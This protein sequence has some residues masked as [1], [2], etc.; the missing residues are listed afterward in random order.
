MEYQLRFGSLK[1]MLKKILITMLIVIVGWT[2]LQPP[3]ANAA[4]QLAAI[5]VGAIMFWGGAALV[6]STGIALGLDPVAMG[7][8][9]QFGE[10]VWNGSNELM[11]DSWQS[12][13]SA[14]QW[15][16]T[17]SRYAVTWTAEQFNYLKTKW[18]EHFGK[19]YMV[20]GNGKIKQIINLNAT[21]IPSQ[22]TLFD[23]QTLDNNT[24][25]NMG[26]IKFTNGS[27]T[28]YIREIRLNE[29]GYATY[30]FNTT[31][32]GSESTGYFDLHGVSTGPYKNAY[33][34][35]AAL[36]ASAMT[37]GV[38]TIEPFFSYYTGTT[39]NHSGSITFPT[40]V[41]RDFAFPAPTGTLNGDGSVNNYTYPTI[42]HIGGVKTNDVGIGYTPTTG[43]YDQLSERDSVNPIMLEDFIVQ[44]IPETGIDVFAPDMPYVDLDIVFNPSDAANKTLD[45]VI[46]PPIARWDGVNFRLTPIADGSADIV[47][48]AP[49]IPKTIT[50]PLKVTGT[51]VANPDSPTG[52]IDW[53]NGFWDKFISVLKNLFV[54]VAVDFSPI[55]NVWVDRFPAIEKISSALSGLTTL[56]YDQSP[57]KFD[58]II[59]GHTY[60]FIDLTFIP[61]NWINMARTFMRISIWSG[62]IFMVLREW[63][64]RPHVG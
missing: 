63:R 19:G 50:I 53:L 58:F 64:P 2:S 14:V 32:G 38:N 47:I 9:R 11:K 17:Q 28:R 39:N 36:A 42:G 23:P 10:D 33:A 27:S 35:Y 48:Y 24:L 57:P 13:L 22:L 15:G 7:A 45:V 40:N 25:K 4:L 26:E 30:R 8:I 60:T 3:K 16:E 34:A 56:N 6:A 41:S 59:N 43:A 12:T 51:G 44:G 62:F 31:A 5:P 18:Q 55:G 61:S 1:L 29:N 52:I 37:E 20:D 49:A 46:N 54:P 21:I